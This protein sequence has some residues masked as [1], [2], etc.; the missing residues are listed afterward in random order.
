V[1]R[2]LQEFLS[3]STASG[4]MLLLAALMALAWANSPWGDAYERLWR[5]PAELRLGSWVI[6]HD[7]R[8]WVNDGLMTLFFLVVGLEIKREFQTGELQDRQA[9]ALPVV[10]AIGGMIVPALIYLA[11][12]AGG[13]GTA[14]WGI[15]MATDI[16]FA[17]GVLVLAARHAPSGLKPFILTLAIVDDIGAII[18][19]ALFYASGVSI[20]FLAAAAAL[21]LLM[22]ALRRVGVK[23]TP[24][25]LGL[26]ALVWLA[27]YE[28]GVHPTI[29]GVVLGLMAPAESYQRPHAVSAEARRTADLTMD[30][31]EPPDA[32]A[33][34]WLRLASLSREAV[35]PLTRTEHALLPWTSFV[36][37]PLFAFAN[38]GV[39]LG[40]EQLADAWASRVT[41]G[42][43]LGL[44]IG[45]VV[46]ISGAAAIAVA[47]RV[48]RLP[49]GVRIIHIVGASAVAGIGFTVS[50]F[51]AE[52]AFDDESLIAEAKVGIL[53]A[54][55][56]AGL[57]GWF[58]FR[59]SPSVDE[60]TL[61]D[62]EERGATEAGSG[63]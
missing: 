2:P 11:L 43:V 23:A 32:D 28:S 14:G 40:G 13:E 60:E 56:L 62:I 10:A 12:N 4:I 54:S 19:I 20:L 3:T 25:F 53:A 55:I 29:A 6:G 35:S 27:T 7:L 37:I 21:C 18:V 26:G 15:P 22:L 63:H 38:A 8:H 59:L 1:L 42:V 31:P 5:T 39:R 9:A 24:V 50:L 48:A 46:G 30:D 17:L 49:A 52:L 47:T 51:I 45:K 57:L 41:L 16:A 61:T 58:V 34:Q 36:I 44:V 33:A